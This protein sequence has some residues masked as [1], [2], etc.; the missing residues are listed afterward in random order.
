[1]SESKEVS[2][3]TDIEKSNQNA[4]ISSIKETMQKELITDL[5]K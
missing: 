3:L 1:M 5:K 2:G 4:G